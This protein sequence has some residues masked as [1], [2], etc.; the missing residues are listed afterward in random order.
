MQKSCVHAAVLSTH[1]VPLSTAT[2]VAD[3]VDG[4]F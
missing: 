1:S 3:S 2:A 4:A